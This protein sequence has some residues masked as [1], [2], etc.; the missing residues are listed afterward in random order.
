MSPFFA[1]D[2]LDDRLIERLQQDVGRIGHQLAAGRDDLV[3]LDQPA[4][5]EQRDDQ[6]EDE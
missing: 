1:L 6:Q 4:G 3:D 2:A 5:G